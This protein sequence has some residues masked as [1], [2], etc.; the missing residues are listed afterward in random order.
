MATTKKISELLADDPADPLDGTEG[1]EVVQDSNTKGALVSQILDY[2]AANRAELGEAV[3]TLT[4]A[5]NIAVN[6]SLANCFRVTL[7]GNRT[8]DNPT[9]LIDGQQLF[10]RIKQDGT[11]SRTLAYGSKYKWAGGVAGV[12]ST[13]AGT[14]DV[15]ACQYDATDDTL[16]CVLN[17]AF[18]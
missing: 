10:F 1:L 5:T 18:A 2:I 14:L 11:G 9:N 8:L 16:V 15:L 12:L 17:K 4:D 3:I 7:G 13:A 6:A